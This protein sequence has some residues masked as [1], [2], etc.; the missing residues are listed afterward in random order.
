V[1]KSIANT[2][3]GGGLARPTPGG[4]INK[5]TPGGKV[6]DDDWHV[7]HGFDSF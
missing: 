7:E 1:T 6:G 3:P 5:P 4:D 2:S